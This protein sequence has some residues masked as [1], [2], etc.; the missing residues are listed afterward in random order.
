MDKTRTISMLISTLFMGSILCA[1]SGLVWALAL[2]S[3]IKSGIIIG[4]ICG[5][6]IGL[7]IFIGNKSSL[8]SGNTKNKEFAFNSGAT[9]IG[10]FV[11]STIIAII[12]GLVRWIF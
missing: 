3:Q 5:L 2:A 4:G 10:L 7:L 8:F 1:I 12:T 11:I 9:M 6:T